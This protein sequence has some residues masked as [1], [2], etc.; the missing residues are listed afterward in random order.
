MF[1]PGLDLQ[2]ANLW[3]VLQMPK[4]INIKIILLTNISNF[5]ILS[6]TRVKSYGKTGNI[7]APENHTKVPSLYMLHMQSLQIF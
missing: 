6:Y 7:E 4:L 1:Q 5:C 2:N 3:H